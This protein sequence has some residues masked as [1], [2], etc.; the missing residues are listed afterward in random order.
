MAGGIEGM[1]GRGIGVDIEVFGTWFGAEGIGADFVADGM[2]E[3]GVG[4]EETG[5]GVAGRT[6]LAGTGVLSIFLGV[7]TP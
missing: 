1:T 5:T 4:F 3:V 6:G 2:L 7:L